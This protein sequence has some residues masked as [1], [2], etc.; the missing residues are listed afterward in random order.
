MATI[1]SLEEKA[2]RYDEA[3]ERAKERYKN[4]PLYDKEEHY[5]TG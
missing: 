2:K 3:F 5:R 1:K 4:M